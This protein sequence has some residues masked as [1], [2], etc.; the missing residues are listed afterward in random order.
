M[1]ISM[2][3][4]ALR[5]LEQTSCDRPH[6]L[7]VSLQVY[8]FQIRIFEVNCVHVANHLLHTDLLYCSYFLCMA[9]YSNG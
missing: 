5:V 9:Y 4:H 7:G 3:I 1:A 2:C 8:H 6:Y